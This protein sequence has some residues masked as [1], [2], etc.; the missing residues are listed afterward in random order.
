M[1]T[2]SARS[3]R[4]RL[5]RPANVTVTFIFHTPRRISLQAEDPAAASGSGQITTESGSIHSLVWLLTYSAFLRSN[6]TASTLSEPGAISH[7]LWTRLPEAKTSLLP[8]QPQPFYVHQHVRGI[9]KHAPC[10]GVLRFFLGGSLRT[11]S[12][13]QT[14][15]GA[16]QR[17]NPT[18]CRR[19]RCSCGGNIQKTRG[20]AKCP[21]RLWPSLRRLRL[22]LEY[23]EVSF[24]P[25]FRR[26]EIRRH[27]GAAGFDRGYVALSSFL[28]SHSFLDSP[29]V[30]RLCRK[31]ASQPG[32]AIVLFANNSIS[33]LAI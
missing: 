23:L 19:P 10:A 18:R 16:R 4:D 25:R 8:R 20:A 11:S 14:R 2:D 6:N 17:A 13:L 12:P 30:A 24:N 22:R 9:R 32:I 21:V 27:F 33:C 29:L 26:D 28:L 31:V 3:C 7:W 15:S 1:N 5:W